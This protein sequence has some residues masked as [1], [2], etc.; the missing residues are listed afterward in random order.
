M[1]F[2]GSSNDRNQRDSFGGRGGDRRGRGRGG[3]GWGG[4][5]DATNILFVRN[6]S[7]S[8]TSDSLSEAFDG[9][10]SAR[11]VMERDDPNRSRGFG[12]VEFDS[13]EL[14]KEAFNYMKGQEVDGRQIY[15]D[16]ADERSGDGGGFRG[17]R[18]GRGGGRWGGGR[19]GGGRGGRGGFNRRPNPTKILFVKNLS[20][21][22]TNDS[23][24]EAFDG[25]SSARV[26]M[27]RDNPNRSRGFGFVEFD[28]IESAKEAFYSMKGQ[29]VDG[30]QIYLDFDE[31]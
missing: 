10:S 27:E 31:Q 15:L 28:S 18:G 5:G 22:T 12:F 6:L 8:T 3:G 20:F 21:S 1:E 11:V 16:F 4:R 23:L 14:A 19:G 9:C 2:E 30:R 24:S 25:C 7:F 17:G 29:E 26:V 13:V